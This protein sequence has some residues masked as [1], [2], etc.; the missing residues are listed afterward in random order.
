MKIQ[1]ALAGCRTETVPEAAI[2]DRDPGLVSFFNVNTPEE[3][4]RAE[5]LLAETQPIDLDS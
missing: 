3:L 1:L 4:A 5:R 2:R